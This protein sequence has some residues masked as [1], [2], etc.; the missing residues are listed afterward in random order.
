[1]VLSQLALINV[2][3]SAVKASATTA[4]KWRNHVPISW[5]VLTSHNLMVLSSLPVARILPSGLNAIAKTA[6]V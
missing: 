4:Q 5:K 6:G 1:M 2:L 3:L